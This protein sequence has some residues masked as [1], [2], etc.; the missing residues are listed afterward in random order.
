MVLAAAI[1]HGSSIHMAFLLPATVSKF[2]K[3]SCLTDNGRLLKVEEKEKMELHHEP[4]PGYRAVFY[5]TLA[6]ASIYL[7]IIFISSLI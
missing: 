7:C 5:I 6:V 1:F 4:V 2:S 3:T